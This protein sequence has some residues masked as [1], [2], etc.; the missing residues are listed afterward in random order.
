LQKEPNFPPDWR[1]WYTFQ[2][3]ADYKNN[4]GINTTIVTVESI[5]KQPEYHWNGTFGDGF[6]ESKFN[7]TQCHIRNFIKDA[8]INWGD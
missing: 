8:Y 1:W 5:L 4:N 7:D 2:D 3:L 6:N